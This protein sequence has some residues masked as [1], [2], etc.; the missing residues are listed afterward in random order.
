M[1]RI[2]NVDYRRNAFTYKFQ[3]LNNQK[4]IVMLM[5]KN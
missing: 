2:L 5:S 4:N 3:K 1:R